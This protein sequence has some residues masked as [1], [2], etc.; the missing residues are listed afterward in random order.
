MLKIKTA[1]QSDFVNKNVRSI[2][3]KILDE[4]TVCERKIKDA[5]S[6]INGMNQLLQQG[7]YDISIEEVEQQFGDEIYGSLGYYDEN[8]FNF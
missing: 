2:L 1:Q 3:S 8:F 7:R 6:V 5:N 4:K